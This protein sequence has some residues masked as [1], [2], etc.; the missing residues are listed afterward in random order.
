MLETL[1]YEML[2]ES[3]FSVARIP[4]TG[5]TWLRYSGFLA[6]FL[7]NSIPSVSILFVFIV[8]DYS[9]PTV[10][11]KFLSVISTVQQH[12]YHTKG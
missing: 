9:S 8:A 1:K 6:E 3:L 10:T 11:L 7:S 12:S 4:E 2:G 5:R